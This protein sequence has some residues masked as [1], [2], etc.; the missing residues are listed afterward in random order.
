VLATFVSR[1]DQ[2]PTPDPIGNDNYAFNVSKTLGARVTCSLLRGAGE[3]FGKGSQYR[4]AE[5]DCVAFPNDTVFP[6]GEDVTF[7]AP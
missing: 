7:P 2:L 6:E 5:P 1:G 3:V 4:D